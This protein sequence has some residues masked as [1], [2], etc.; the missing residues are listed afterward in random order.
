LF[1]NIW[2]L[3]GSALLLHHGISQADGGVDQI[4][5]LQFPTG[6]GFRFQHPDGISAS[7]AEAFVGATKVVCG[8]VGGVRRQGPDES[9]A[10]I[11]DLD[12]GYPNQPATVVVSTLIRRELG[13]NFDSRVAPL[14]VCAIGKIEKARDGIQV[15][16][17]DETNLL[18]AAR[19]PA[20]RPEDFFGVPL[21]ESAGIAMPR[22]VRR[23]E[24]QYPARAMRAKVQGTVVVE[25]VVQAGG[26]VGAARITRSLDALHGLDDEALRVVRLWRFGPAVP[27]IHLVDAVIVAEL[28]FRFHKEP[29][30]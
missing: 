20:T 2:L 10:T 26:T 21:A 15:R 5:K 13:P 4:R 3:V 8:A 16:I 1:F 19:P 29:D 18:G 27:G 7:E 14:D 24:P 25:A 9:G 17:T 22:L 23:V 28:E 6:P 11:L 30:V 12:V